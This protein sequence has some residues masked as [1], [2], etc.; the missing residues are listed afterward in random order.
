MHGGIYAPVSPKNQPNPYLKDIKDR[1]I[2]IGDKN[3]TLINPA[4]L[5]I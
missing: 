2:K 1:D 5:R 3:L 4:D